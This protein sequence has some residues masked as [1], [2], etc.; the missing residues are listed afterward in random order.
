MLFLLV[1]GCPAA[2]SEVELTIALGAEQV[3]VQATLRDVR[4][5]T[6]DPAEA[7]R[8]FQEVR[9]PDAPLASKLLRQYPWM[10]RLQRW[11]WQVRGEALDLALTGAMPRSEF[12]TCVAR[13]PEQRTAPEEASSPCRGFPLWRQGDEYRSILDAEPPGLSGPDWIALGATRWPIRE[14]RLQT[15]VRLA[16][17]W[18][19]ASSGPALPSFELNAREP[20]AVSS[21]V[22]LVERLH[23]AFIAGDTPACKALQAEA[24]RVLPPRIES[25]F[26]AQLRR[27]RLWLIEALVRS[28]GLQP[29]KTLP[30]P[31]DRRQWVGPVEPEYVPALLPRQRPPEVLLLKLARL[32][33]QAAVRFAGNEE[34]GDRDFTSALD[35]SEL[36]VLCGELSQ[37]AASWRRP[38]KHLL[39]TRP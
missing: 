28:Q 38:C 3:E 19:P 23:R 12:D 20:E 22:A 36:Q 17:K 37:K 26:Q 13:T 6:Q 33:D 30:K 32:S 16:S 11:E 18:L 7:L 5:W 8:A 27:E 15:R 34:T 31:L 4:L 21:Y 2:P 29:V 9:A 25:L 39:D 10:P 1:C 24:A 35:E 14:Q